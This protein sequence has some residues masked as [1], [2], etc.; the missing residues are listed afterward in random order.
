MSTADLEK[1]CA[2]LTPEQREKAIAT[3]RAQE[4]KMAEKLK[5]GTDTKLKQCPCRISNQTTTSTTAS[6][7]PERSIQPAKHYSL[8][9]PMANR[10]ARTPASLSS[11]VRSRLVVSL[12]TP[13]RCCS[14]SSLAKHCI[15]NPPIKKEPNISVGPVAI[16]ASSFFAAIQRLFYSATWPREAARRPAIKGSRGEMPCYKPKRQSQRGVILIPHTTARGPLPRS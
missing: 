4:I 9:S 16:Y 2:Q 11:E 7:V 15:Y 3:F 5:K 14:S 12:R 1:L 13:D 10:S 8:R 6:N